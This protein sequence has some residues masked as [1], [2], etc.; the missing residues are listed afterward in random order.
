MMKEF[1]NV[2]SFCTI[3][4]IMA[5]SVFCRRGRAHAR[6]HAARCHGQQLPNVDPRGWRVED[7]RTKLRVKEQERS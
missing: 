4:V 7:K 1:E 2:T 5:Y 3:A 6:G